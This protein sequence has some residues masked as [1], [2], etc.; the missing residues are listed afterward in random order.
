VPNDGLF[1]VSIHFPVDGTFTIMVYNLLGGKLFE[2]RDV[3]TVGGKF[4]TR[5]DLRPLD[6]GLYFVVLMNSEYKVVKRILVKN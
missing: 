6:N 4:K 1:T 3:N 5:I 2:L